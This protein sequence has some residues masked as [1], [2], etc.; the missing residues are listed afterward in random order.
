MLRHLIIILCTIAFVLI[1]LGGAACA[2]KNVLVSFT[3]ASEDCVVVAQWELHVAAVGTGDP[4]PADAALAGLVTAPTGVCGVDTLTEIIP[5]GI[6]AG[7]T[8]F[9]LRAV[10]T[11]GTKSGFSNADDAVVPVNAP[12]IVEILFQ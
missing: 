6:A 4:T 1:A 12:V 3:Q 11:D 7:N 5:T 2:T 8:R 10:A 9:W